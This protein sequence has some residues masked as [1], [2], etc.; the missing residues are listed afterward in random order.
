MSQFP[1]PD[2]RQANSQKEQFVNNMMNSYLDD[3]QYYKNVYQHF[4][5]SVQNT[6]LIDPTLIIELKQIQSQNLKLR[7]RIQQ[8]KDGASPTSEEIEMVQR[9]LSFLSIPMDISSS[10]GEKTVESFLRHSYETDLNLKM[11]L[12]TKLNELSNLVIIHQNLQ[13]KLEIYQSSK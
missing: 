2:V 3:Q 9:R 6:Q 12:Q 11:Q 1:K 4:N 13:K 10:S 5:S 7:E 8:L